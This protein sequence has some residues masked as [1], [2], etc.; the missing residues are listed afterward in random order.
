M[1][2][3]FSRWI[4]YLVCSSRSFRMF[5]PL[6]KYVSVS[7][8]VGN[9]AQICRAWDRWKKITSCSSS[10]VR[11]CLWCFFVWFYL[12]IYTYISRPVQSGLAAR[13]LFFWWEI[14]VSIFGSTGLGFIY[15]APQ[16]L[17]KS[18]L[19]ERWWCFFLVEERGA[20]GDAGIPPIKKDS[21][22]FSIPFLVGIWRG[23]GII[24]N[25]RVSNRES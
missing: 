5:L 2:A 22:H 24:G 3:S 16:I 9:P 20:L 15:W 14:F 13:S 4:A 1:L 11:I 18:P 12:H 23:G 21:Q 17:K 19:Q 7:L 6:M 10:A 8:P 25:R